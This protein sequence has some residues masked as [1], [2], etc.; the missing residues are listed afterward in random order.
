MCCMY[1]LSVDFEA[2]VARNLSLRPMKLR[3]LLVK[4]HVAGLESDT[5][6]SF[7]RARDPEDRL[8]FPPAFILRSS[9]HSIR[10]VNHGML[11]LFSVSDK[12]ARQGCGGEYALLGRAADRTESEC[13]LTLLGT[14]SDVCSPILKVVEKGADDYNTLA[15]FGLCLVLAIK[16]CSAKAVSRHGVT[17]LARNPSR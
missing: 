11:C 7:V 4:T 1:F 8:Q 17:S 3:A 10:S 2:I 9:I 14:I 5:A 15:S 6:H 16:W 12:R 13:P